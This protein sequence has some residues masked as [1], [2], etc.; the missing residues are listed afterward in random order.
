MRPY[1]GLNETSPSLGAANCATAATFVTS[2]GSSGVRH[3]SDL[4][5]KSAQVSMGHWVRSSTL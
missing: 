1:A 2:W 5:L 4:I 3:A